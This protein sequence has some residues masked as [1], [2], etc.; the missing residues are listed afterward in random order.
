[1]WVLF[2]R[3][4]TTYTI[5]PLSL[6]GTQG[7]DY[8]KEHTKEELRIIGDTS[9]LRDNSESQEWTKLRLQG[10]TQ[11]RNGDETLTLV[12]DSGEVKVILEN[13]P[14]PLKG[15]WKTMPT[16]GDSSGGGTGGSGTG[17]TRGASAN[18]YLSVDAARDRIGDM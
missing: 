7:F 18:P 1:M 13:Q 11:Y 6:D 8:I 4:P 10:V 17:G 2:E 14:R 5:L 16:E 3:P 15:T 9:W 12:D